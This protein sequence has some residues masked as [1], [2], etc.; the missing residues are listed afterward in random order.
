MDRHEM[1]SRT[2]QLALRVMRLCEALPNN[3]T[4][5]SIG[6]QVVRSATSVGANDRASGR[7]RSDAE[8][9]AKLGIVEE[10]AD[11]T[12]YWLELIIESQMIKP[13][14]VEPLLKEANELVAIVVAMR[15]SVKQ[16]ISR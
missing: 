4:G 2:K 9:L 3:G 16:R 8:F 1:Q 14:L 13:T 6:K 15:K 10:Q 5:W 7:A 12:C 11:E